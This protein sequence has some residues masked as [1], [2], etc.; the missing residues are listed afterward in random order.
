MTREQ[1]EEKL[2][3]LIHQEPFI[4]FQVEMTDGEVLVVPHPRLA[5]NSS[6]AGF[7]GLD[8]GLV[9]IDFAKVRSIE[10]FAPKVGV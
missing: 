2:I 10:T 1:I 3:G 8:G 6:G 5:I 9:D 4:P 7:I